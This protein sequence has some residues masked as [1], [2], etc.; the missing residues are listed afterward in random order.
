MKVQLKD[1]MLKR[2]EMES[3]ISLRSERLRAAGVG[4]NGNLL[5]KEVSKHQIISFRELRGAARSL[6]GRDSHRATHERT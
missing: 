2:E 6:N 4:M 5:D 3:D 1:L